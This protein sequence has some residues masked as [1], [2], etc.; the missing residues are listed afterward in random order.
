MAGAYILGALAIMFINIGNVG[1]MFGA[2]FKFA[3]TE[4][5]AFGGVLGTVIKAMTQGFKR[6]VFSNEAGLGSSVI[7][8]SS[9]NVREPV[10][11]G[12][13]GIFE[14]FFDTF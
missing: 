8:H 13:W 11:Q 6:G 3:F 5:A 9:S 4:R 14:V 1:S 7:V 2:I 12:M 10:R